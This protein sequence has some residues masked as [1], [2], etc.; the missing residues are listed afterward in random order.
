VPATPALWLEEQKQEDLW[1]FLGIKK[2]TM[3]TSSSFMS[4]EIR[5]K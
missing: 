1:S 2:K 5:Q 3:M 4:Q